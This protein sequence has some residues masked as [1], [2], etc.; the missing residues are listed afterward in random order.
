M[1]PTPP[2][3]TRAMALLVHGTFIE[4]LRRRDIYVLLILMSIFSAGMLLARV[5]GVTD[6]ATSAFLL[7]LG[8]TMAQYF[9]HVL[10]LLMAVR[11]LSAERENRTLFSLLACPVSRTAILAGKW[12]ASWLGGLTVFLV[13]LL[14]AW[15]PAPKI[16]EPDRLL[17]VQ[18]LVL[19]VLSLGLI[20]AL[21]LWL[22]LFMPHSLALI[23]T[24]GWY[25]AGHILIGFVKGGGA[26]HSWLS[27]YLVDFNRLN[28]VTRYTDGIAA[29]D[30]LTLAGLML[31]AMLFMA[32]FLVTGTVT[33]HRR[34]L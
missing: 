16:E 14:L 11:G 18:T 25:F 20:T 4:L 13:L 1:I 3:T 29:L 34:P 21:G 8:M 22:S 6:A 10:A 26:V 15:I 19:Q 9:A 27:A 33:F 17:L 32:V 5:V 24:G 2:S 30:P 31:Y 23:V 28:L 12:L 7:N